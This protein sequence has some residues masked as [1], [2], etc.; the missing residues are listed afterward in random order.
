MLRLKPVLLLLLV[1][2][3]DQPVAKGPPS[4]PRP[5]LVFD[6]LTLRVYRNGA[7]QLLVR[8]SHVELMRSNGDLRAQNA[9]FDFYVDAVTLDAP[10]LS[11][12]LNSLSFDATGG[13]TFAS[14]DPDPTSR[15]VATTP[16]AHFEGK[17]GARGVATGTAPIA[18]RG[19]QSSRPFSLD[20][21]G[22]RF[23]V[24]AQHATF[25]A[26]QSKVGSP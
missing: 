13:V 3:C 15:F 21:H 14:A 7:P 1:L 25:D 8:S 10:L 20:A 6:G 26:V 18:V 12:N 11:G 5:E 9:R 24:D 23:D 2:G 16:T 4:A 22:F 19:Q 17:E